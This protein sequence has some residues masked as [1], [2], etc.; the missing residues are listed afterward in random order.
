MADWTKE[1]KTTL[2]QQVQ[3]NVEIW[4]PRHED[5]SKRDKVNSKWQDIAAVLN[6]EG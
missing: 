5:H 3:S 4:N 1:R 6:C 2:I